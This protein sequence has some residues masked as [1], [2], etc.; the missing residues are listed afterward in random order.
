MSVNEQGNINPVQEAGEIP[1]SDLPVEK[2]MIPPTRD[3]AW[4][5]EKDESGNTLPESYILH[6][7]TVSQLPGRTGDERKNGI[8]VVAGTGR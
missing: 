7:H 3:S 8:P 6:V 4:L 2:S 1:E 5:V